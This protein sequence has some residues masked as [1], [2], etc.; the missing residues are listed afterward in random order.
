MLRDV[1]MYLYLHLKWL[2]VECFQSAVFTTSKAERYSAYKTKVW[3]SL[4][5]ISHFQVRPS[6]QPLGITHSHC[7]GVG[8]LPNFLCLGGVVVLI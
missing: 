6:G 1:N 7:P 8:F 4:L 3:K 2:F 5:C